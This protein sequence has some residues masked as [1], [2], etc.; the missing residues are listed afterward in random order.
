[1]KAAIITIVTTFALA[2]AAPQAA[3]AW[4]HR[5]SRSFRTSD[6]PSKARNVVSRMTIRDAS[7][8][9]SLPPGVSARRTGPGTFKA[10]SPM[11]NVTAR[12]SV[13]PARGGG[14]IVTERVTSRSICPGAAAA[15]GSIHA[16]AT[17]LRQGYGNARSRTR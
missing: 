17:S 15:A 1:M 4:E 16:A 5:T 13:T 9:G 3:S 14:S 11:A 6:S 2:A 12:V 10:S 8:F 7:R